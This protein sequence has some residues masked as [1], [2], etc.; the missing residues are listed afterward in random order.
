MRTPR[1]LP[2]SPGIPQIVIPALRRLDYLAITDRL[3]EVHR[4]LADMLEYLPKDIGLVFALVELSAKTLT[5][6]RLE[7]EKAQSEHDHG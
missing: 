6:A 1:P 5:V 3:T 2:D 7:L 4:E